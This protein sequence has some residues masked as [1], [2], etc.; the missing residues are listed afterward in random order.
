MDLSKGGIEECGRQDN[1]CQQ[2]KEFISCRVQA[3][4]TL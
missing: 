2:N 3:Q 1:K 4:P